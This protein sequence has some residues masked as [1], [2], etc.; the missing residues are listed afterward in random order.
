MVNHVTE[1]LGAYHDGELHGARLRHVEGHL[2]ECATC[3]AELDEIR[4]LSTLLQ[5]TSSIGDFP[6]SERFVANLAISLPRQSEQPQTPNVL[7]IAW[8]LIPVG[9]LGIW[10]FIDIT[11]SL[12][13]VVTLAVDAALLSGNL[14]WLQ[15]NPLQMQWFATAMNLFGNQLG[16]PGREILSVLNDANL[17][18]TQL[19]RI[20]IPQAIVAV[21]YLGWLLFWWLR[22]Q[23]QPSQNTVNIF[24]S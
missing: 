12:S 18:T 19:A 10:L 11:L 5:D 13:S 21:S 24:K 16:A 23:Q 2:V 6:H 3:Q 20:L 15:G 9:L 17:F 7:K 4:N 1:W 14:V 22:H 8:W